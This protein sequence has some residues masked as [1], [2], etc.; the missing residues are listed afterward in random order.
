[1]RESGSRAVFADVNFRFMPVILAQNDFLR[2]ADL[3]PGFNFEGGVVTASD[4]VE[5]GFA[6]R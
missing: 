6:R 4:S 1:M 3:L 5:P 2:L